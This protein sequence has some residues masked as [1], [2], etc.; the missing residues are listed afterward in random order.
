VLNDILLGKESSPRPVPVDPYRTQSE[1]PV[2]PSREATCVT[3]RA[4]Y[5]VRGTGSAGRC[6]ACF[7]AM[8]AKNQADTAAALRASAEQAARAQRSHRIFGAVVLVLVLIAAAAFRYGMRRQAREDAA[9][10]AGYH[11]YSEYERDR[12]AVYPTDGYSYRVQQF[13]N[14]MCACPDL[15]CSRD[16]QAQYRRFAQTG[17]PDDDARAS[18]EH[19]DARVWDCAA[20]LESK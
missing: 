20:T 10:A 16:V 15:A 7:A 17:E 14:Q 1:V 5:A 13:A 9:Q 19:D 2:A 8:V 18:V 4:S 6:P 11:S 12:D 3:C